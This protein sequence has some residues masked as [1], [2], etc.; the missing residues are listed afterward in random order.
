MPD[1]D[2]EP[3][4]ACSDLV[5]PPYEEEDA[6]DPGVENGP[7]EFKDLETLLRSP[8]YT[9]SFER[10]FRFLVSLGQMQGS[11]EEY[12]SK[13][14]RSWIFTDRVRSPTRFE[15]GLAPDVIWRRVPAHDERWRDFSMIAPRY[16]TLGTS[17]ADCERSLSA[18]KSIQGLHTTKIGVDL[19][20][21]VLSEKISWQSDKG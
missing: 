9:L 2:Q 8:V 1:A 19:L 11:E 4:A 17:E 21:D 7:Y 20:E 10:A 5:E 18:Q 13:V 3:P 12:V 16:V 15:R 6:I 14:F